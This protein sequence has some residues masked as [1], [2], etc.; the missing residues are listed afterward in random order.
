MWLVTGASGFVGGHI[1]RVLGEKG[2]GLDRRSVGAWTRENLR[3]ALD[4]VDG[5]VHAA[6]VVHQ[7]STPAA[8]YERFNVE[9]TRALLDAAEDVGVKRFVFL[10]SI[11]VHGETPLQPIDE[12]TPV[13][14]EADYA[15]TKAMAE[16][17]VAARTGLAPAVLRLCPVY[18]R[19]DKGNVRTVIRAIW[20][21]RFFVPGDGRTRKSIVHVSTVAAIAKAALEGSARGMFIVADRRSPSMRELADEVAALLGRRRPIS[22]PIP[23][24]RAAAGAVATGASLARIR[25][26]ISR[27]LVEKSLTSSVC[28]PSRVERELGV[29]CEVDL[30]GALADEIDWLRGIGAL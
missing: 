26:P 9:G 13:A 24:L 2:R 22:V 19:G 4:G 29:R 20:G 15:R 17:L 25:T 21:R 23:L 11:K 3:R 30:T 12:K 8:E 5:V 10:S 7:P 6:S 1:V 14:A 27:S 16:E 18:G 28:D